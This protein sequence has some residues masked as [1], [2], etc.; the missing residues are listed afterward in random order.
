MLFFH[1]RLENNYKVQ[2]KIDVKPYAPMRI[3]FCDLGMIE[4]IFSFLEIDHN[5]EENL[6]T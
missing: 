4:I 5:Y 2:T 6:L 1:Y 3:I